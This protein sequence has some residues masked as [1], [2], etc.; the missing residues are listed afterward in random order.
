MIIVIVSIKSSRGTPLALALHG[1]KFTKK[2][3]KLS[4]SNALFESFLMIGS[5]S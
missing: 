2:N 3:N 1:I 5:K 4:F